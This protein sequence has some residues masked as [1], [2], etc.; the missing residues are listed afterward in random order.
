MLIV[1]ARLCHCCGRANTLRAGPSKTTITNA[2]EFV[3][4]KGETNMDQKISEIEWCLEQDPV[5]LWRLRELALTHGG[6]V[7]GTFL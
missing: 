6:L 3:L 4:C 1:K 7:T 5:D 2:V